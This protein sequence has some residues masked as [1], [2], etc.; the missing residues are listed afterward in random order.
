[1]EHVDVAVIGAG[2]AGAVAAGCLAG[3]GKKVVVIE[4]ERFPRFIIGESLLPR[5]NDLLDKCGFHKAVEQAGFMT[6][7]GAVFIKGDK[8]ERFN[9]D[10]RFGDGWD[11]AYNVPRADFDM[12]L[13][14]EAEKMGADIRYRVKVDNVEFHDDSATLSCSD[15]EANSQYSV[16]AKFVMDCSGYGRVLPKLLDLDMPS[17]LEYRES[18]FTHVK[19]DLRPEG[20]EEGYIWIVDLPQG[21]WIWVIP[22]SNGATSVG[23]VAKP[24]VIKQAGESDDEALKTL[25]LQESSLKERLGNMEFVMP[26]IRIDGYSIGIKKL[27][28]HRWILTGNAMEFLDPVFSSGV[29]LSMESAYKAQDVVARFLDGEQVDFQK[30]YSDY[31]MRG[32]DCFRVYINAWYEN[33][34]GWL[35]Y[36]KRKPQSIKERICS[37]LAGYAWDENNAYAIDAASS[38]EAAISTI[39]PEYRN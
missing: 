33:K 20:R 15:L 7:G 25:L 1:M 4:K 3:K 35:F 24:S 29:T 18:L 11:F 30:E 27:F 22:F 5:T 38:L 10:E 8:R 28:G 31:V 32:V 16:S 37:V 12:I 23:V 19:G 39:P 17:D 9:F 2:P 36:S 26:A 6:K 14:Q 21:G 13:A 34:L